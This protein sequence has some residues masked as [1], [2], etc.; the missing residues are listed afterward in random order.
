MDRL[1]GGGQGA[2]SASN[3]GHQKS[4]NSLLGM[5]PVRLLAGLVGLLCENMSGRTCYPWRV[6]RWNLIAI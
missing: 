2:S 5:L 6:L 4:T 3:V 1:V